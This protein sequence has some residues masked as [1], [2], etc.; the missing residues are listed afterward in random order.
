MNQLALTDRDGR[1]AHCAE[2]INGTLLKL[3]LRF[4]DLVRIYIKLLSKVGQCA[5]TPTVA[6]AT[7][8]VNTAECVRRVLFVIFWFPLPAL[9]QA[10]ISAVALIALPELPAPPLMQ[11]PSSSS[12]RS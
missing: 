11:S 3:P 4:G 6:S 10:Q 9:C 7:F 5:F 12:E 2:H 1:L 8:A